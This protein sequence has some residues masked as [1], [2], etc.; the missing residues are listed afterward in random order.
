[1]RLDHRPRWAGL[2]RSGGHDGAL[3]E[4]AGAAVEDVAQRGEDLHG[5]PFRFVADQAVDLGGGQH[6]SPLP[7]QRDQLGGLPQLVG[8]HHLPQPPVVV[9]SATSRRHLAR[10]GRQ[11]GR[12]VASKD[13]PQRAGAKSEDTDV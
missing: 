8:G 7:Q 2:F 4:I 10:R 3:D 12:C 11:P 5:H 6:H 9:E 13:P 1:M